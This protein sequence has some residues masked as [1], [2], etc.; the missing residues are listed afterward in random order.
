MSEEFDKSKAYD[1]I[2][3]E[4]GSYRRLQ[5]QLDEQLQIKKD[6]D[7]AHAVAIATLKSEHEAALAQLVESHN[8]FVANLRSEHAADKAQA[9]ENLM[10]QHAKEIADLKASVL[11][12]ALQDM[13]QRQLADLAAKHA[14]ELAKLK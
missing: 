12:P 5:V 4:N 7:E 10:A 13:Q 6:T 2:M 14:E 11:V 3:G 1:E 8:S 9:I